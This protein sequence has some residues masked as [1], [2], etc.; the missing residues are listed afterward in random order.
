MLAPCWEASPSAQLAV[1]YLAATM[2]QLMMGAAGT[3]YCDDIRAMQLVNNMSTDY[4][5]LRPI[6]P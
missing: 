2:D 4:D 6:G 5:V 1:S 3:E